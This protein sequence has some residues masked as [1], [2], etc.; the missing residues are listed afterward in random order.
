MAIFCARGDAHRRVT[1]HHTL[2]HVA[3]KADPGRRRRGWRL[4]RLGGRD[5]WSGYG[6]DER[7]AGGET[8][9]ANKSK[10]SV[11]KPRRPSLCCPNNIGHRS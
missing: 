4:L 10:R 8:R 9:F 1:A 5:G 7:V 2:L 6:A 3:E 11:D